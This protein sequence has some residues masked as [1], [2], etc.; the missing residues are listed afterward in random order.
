M[1]D[2]KN[3]LGSNLVDL[4]GL[5]A[6]WGKAKEYINNAIPEIPVIGVDEAGN[7]HGI[8]IT[9][10]TDKKVKL[11]LSEG[12]V[13]SGNTNYITGGTAF[14]AMSASLSAAN[15]YTDQEIGELDTKAQGYASNAQSEATTAAKNYTDQEIGKLHEV[16]TSGSYNDLTN[17]PDALPNP[18]S[19]TISINN[20]EVTYDGYAQKSL[21]VNIT[22]QSLGLGAALKYCGITTTALTD[23]DTT[24]TIKINNADHTAETGCVVFYGDKEFVYN[25]TAWEELGYPTDL[26]GYKTK[27]TAVADPTA[28]G[29]STTFIDTIS[30]N[31][32]GEITVTKKTVNFPTIP[33]Y[34]LD[35]ATT[36][37]CEAIV[38]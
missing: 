12:A 33:T 8:G 36:A 29:V 16:A 2:N 31:A 17:T 34:E 15:R 24:K 26:S 10:T 14:T 28:N 22:A 19:L 35:V 27:Q 30:Q 20:N 1:A 18:N 13:A 37:E 38:K 6:F 4:A 11:N 21:T 3:I 23:G 9:L 32:N 7:N 5:T 25:G